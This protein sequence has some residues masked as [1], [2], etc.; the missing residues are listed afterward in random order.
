MRSGLA[1]ADRRPRLP[2]PAGDFRADRLGRLSRD[3]VGARLG[4]RGC[5][6]R[7]S[8]AGSAAGAEACARCPSRQLAAMDEPLAEL[9]SCARAGAGRECRVRRLAARG[10]RHAAATRHRG[11]RRGWPF[12]E[13]RPDDRGLYPRGRSGARRPCRRTSSRRS[14]SASG[15]APHLTP[16]RTQAPPREAVRRALAILAMPQNVPLALRLGWPTA[17]RMWR[18][19]GDTS[20]DFNHYSKRGRCRRSMARPCLPG[21]TTTARASPRPLRSSIAESAT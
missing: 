11:A 8:G 15:S 20:T 6:L 13:A 2:H 5:D 12:R 16:P 7:R 18:L 17:D 1:A 9:R 4:R 10:D 19:A 21:S 3:A 14:R